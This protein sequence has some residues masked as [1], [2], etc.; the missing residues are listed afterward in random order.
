MPDDTYELSSI[1]LHEFT[2]WLGDMTQPDVLRASPVTAHLADDQ[3]K[4]NRVVDGFA[5]LLHDEL[6]QYLAHRKGE[7]TDA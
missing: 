1:L 6:G 3:E 2:Y 5:I 4:L 7:D